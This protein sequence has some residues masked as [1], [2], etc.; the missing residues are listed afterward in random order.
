MNPSII[1]IPMKTTMVIL[2]HIK[3]NMGAYGQTK[4]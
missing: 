2:K 4:G 1:L 3:E